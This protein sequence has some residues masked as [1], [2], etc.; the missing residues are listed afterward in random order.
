MQKPSN[1]E[2]PY[3][4]ARYASEHSMKAAN[5]S[6]GKRMKGHFRKNVPRNIY[7]LQHQ[8]RLTVSQPEV[9]VTLSRTEVSRAAGPDNISPWVTRSC[10]EQPAPMSTDLF[11][12]SLQRHLVPGSFKESPVT[13]ITWNALSAGLHKMSDPWQLLARKTD[14]LRMAFLL[15]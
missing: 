4:V 9:R 12:M 2:T 15:H 3:K 10:P 5:H 11:N 1:L 7:S 13:M 6:C 14:P 8:S